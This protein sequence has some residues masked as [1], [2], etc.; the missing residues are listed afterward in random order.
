VQKLRVGSGHSQIATGHKLAAGRRGHALDSRDHRLGQAHDGLHQR[1]A[2]AKHIAEIGASA[3]RIA[4]PG[5]HFLEVM[6]RRKHRPVC[7]QHHRLDRA[8]RS[9]PGQLFGQRRDHAFG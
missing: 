8:A 9:D 3:V 2:A 7:C 4:A 1:G 5:A 6:A